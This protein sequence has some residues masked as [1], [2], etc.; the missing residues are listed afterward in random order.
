V[1]LFDSCPETAACQ[2]SFV[3]ESL[4]RL[5]TVFTNEEEHVF[6]VDVDTLEDHL[7]FDPKRKPDLQR[8]DK[9]I[10]KSAPGLKRYFHTGTPAGEPGMRF[11]MIG[12]GKFQYLARSGKYV[13]WPAVGVALQ[14]NYISVY[15]SVMKDGAP[16]IQSYSGKLGELKVGRN[17]FSFRT[18]E[19]L[20][21]RLLA[22]LF[23]EADQIFNSDLCRC[24][25]AHGGTKALR[26]TG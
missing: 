16:L 21:V 25:H 19:D 10:R 15:L 6:R 3:H 14:K 11:K 13:D 18:S 17:N 9:L 4:L 7:D 12:Y 5:I 26:A 1:N 20:D 24:I 23:A 8:L 22:S 2:V